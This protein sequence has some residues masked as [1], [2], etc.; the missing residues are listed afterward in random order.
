MTQRIGNQRDPSHWESA[1][2][3]PPVTMGQGEDH[4]KPPPIRRAMR[5]Q[6][7]QCW[8]LPHFLPWCP[9]TQS[10]QACPESHHKHTPHAVKIPARQADE[11]APVREHSRR[12]QKWEER[13]KGGK[14]EDCITF[15]GMT[16]MSQRGTKA[17]PIQELLRVSR[18]NQTRH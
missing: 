3:P 14:V 15:L 7:R 5:A 11:G 12:S 10:H 17:E 13:R 18:R 9:S 2:P 1:P 4:E 16:H 6:G 8:P